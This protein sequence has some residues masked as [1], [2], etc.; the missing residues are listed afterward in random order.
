MGIPCVD[1]AR[2]VNNKGNGRAGDSAHET[3]LGLLPMPA[4]V[5]PLK[6]LRGALHCLHVPAYKSARQREGQCDCARG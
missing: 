5:H 1:H 2:S 4:L 6:A 3:Q